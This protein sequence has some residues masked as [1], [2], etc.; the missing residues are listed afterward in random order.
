MNRLERIK[1]NVEERNYLVSEE[2][3]HLDES[4]EDDVKW[5][6]QRL[7]IAQKALEDIVNDPETIEENENLAY[8]YYK[9]AEEAL[10]EDNHE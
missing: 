7:E 4:H 5:L 6:L 1:K 2:F 8:K 9:I 10:K 3:G